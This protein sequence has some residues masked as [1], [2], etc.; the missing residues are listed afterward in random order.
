MKKTLLFAVPLLAALVLTGCGGLIPGRSAGPGYIP[1]DEAGPPRLSS[2]SYQV[3]GRRYQL[4]AS[5]A[6]YEE[7][8]I[9]TWYGPGFHRR[10]TASGERYNMHALTAAH[11]SLPMDTVVEVHNLNNNRKVNVRIND[12]GPFVE[13]R[14]IDLS[15]KAAKQ[16]ELD[17]KARVRVKALGRA[18]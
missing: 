15:L 17:G 10:K 8:G 14:I 9:A 7:E 13:G 11:K 12:R 2:K 6:G 3:K 18:E 1:F 5:A 4:L 16:I